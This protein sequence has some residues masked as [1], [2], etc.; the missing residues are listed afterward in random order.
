[1]KIEYSGLRDVVR[2]DDADKPQAGAIVVKG[3]GQRRRFLLV[4]SMSGDRWIFPKGTVKKK[5]TSEEAAEREAEEEAGVKARVVA[6]VGGIE[7]QEDDELVRIDYFLL[8]AEEE[9]EM[10]EDRKKRWCTPDEIKELV[11]TPEICSLIE[12]ALPDI[13]A[14]EIGA[15]R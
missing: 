8:A 3:S 11:H 1:M 5:E 4:T 7:M 14:F 12:T 2:R 15:A 9:S 6:Y 10:E 13:M